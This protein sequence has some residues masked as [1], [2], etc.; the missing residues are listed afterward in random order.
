[1]GGVLIWGSEWGSSG[2]VSGVVLRDVHVVGLICYPEWV[3]E[4]G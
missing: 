2:V 4:C 3:M 1:M